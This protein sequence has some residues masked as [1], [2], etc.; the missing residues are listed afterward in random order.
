MEVIPTVVNEEP[1]TLEPSQ[2]NP[3]GGAPTG[4]QPAAPGSK[5][6]PEMLLTSLQ[7]ERD[8]VAR[9]E[10]ELEQAKN[11]NNP[12]PDEALR[13]DVESMKQDLAKREVLEANP[14]LKDKW[15]DLEAFRALPDNQGLSIKTAAKAFII[16][17]N[18]SDL[19][20]VGLESKTGGDRQPVNTGM[21]V[22]QAEELRK[23]NWRGY[24]D[25]L[26][27]GLIPNS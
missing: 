25:A 4:T 18:L 6:P 20:R 10:L 23:N 8:K 13:R 27:K 7:Q 24:Q 26:Q 1:T 12:A 9:L 16:E 2:G 14:I 3:A 11:K 21:T 15:N 22:E 19:S 5:T 17:N